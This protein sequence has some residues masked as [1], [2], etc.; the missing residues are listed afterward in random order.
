MADGGTLIAQGRKRTARARRPAAA[1]NVPV[2]PRYGTRYRGVEHAE[3]VAARRARLIAAGT[4]VFGTK[5]YHGTTV[6][7][8][9]AAAGLTERYFYESFPNSEALLLACYAE[10]VEAQAARIAGAVR[11]SDGTAEAAMRA[12]LTTFLADAERSPAAMRLT[13]IEPRTVSV[14]GD[15]AFRATQRRVAQVLLDVMIKGGLV[16]PPCYSA[17]LLSRALGGALHALV[18]AWF[19]AG[20]DRPLDEMI[21]TCMA[22][23]FAMAAQWRPAPADRGNAMAGNNKGGQGTA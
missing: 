14:A 18:L 9:C 15:A 21:R 16:P 22:V 20:Y 4:E 19:E 7:Q 11:A 6:R 17:E 5:G 10:V 23:Y 3:R 1:G 12:L 13:L 2:E 8:L